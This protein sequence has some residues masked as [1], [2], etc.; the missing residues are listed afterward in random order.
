MNN[1]RFFTV[2]IC[3]LFFIFG[4][5]KNAHIRIKEF[6]VNARDFASTGFTIPGR[7]F[8]GSD[9]K[10][11]GLIYC[12]GGPHA[13]SFENIDLLKQI[14][15]E[16]GINV[17]SFDFRGSKIKGYDE[18]GKQYSDAAKKADYF[19]GG[20]YDYGGIHADDLLRVIDYLKAN[21]A[22][23]IDND[24]LIIAGHSFGGY[25][26]ALAVTDPVL[27]KR[28][29]LAMAISGFFDLGNFAKTNVWSTDDKNPS[30]QQ[31][32]SP[33]SFVQNI[34]QPVIVVHGDPEKDTTTLINRNDTNAFINAAQALN[35]DVQKLFLDGL[36]HEETEES[37][38]VWNFFKSFVEK[39]K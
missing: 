26:V 38:E 11:P 6:E 9:K 37:A 1:V 13:S 7:I 28:F 3:S 2:F 22:D 14:A 20:D 21:H 15:N 39:L 23:I 30:I 33:R 17:V 36:D 32:R 19:N 29:K 12:H 10:T 18:V 34:S 24:K 5:D 8:L 35:K 27:T 25:M 16:Y 31:R 4:C